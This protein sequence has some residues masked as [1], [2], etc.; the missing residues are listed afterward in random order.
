[1]E[2]ILAMIAGSVILACVAAAF[3]RPA[4]DRKDEMED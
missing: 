1:M 3:D 2:A 4:D